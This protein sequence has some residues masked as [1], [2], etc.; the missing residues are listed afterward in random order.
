M[1]FGRRVF[2]FDNDGIKQISYAKYNRLL[3]GN[4]NE[5]LPEYANQRIRTAVVFVEIENRNPVNLVKIDCESI[6]VNQDGKFDQHERQQRMID[7]FGTISVP[8][9]DE[10]L[11]IVI[12]VSRLF[13]QKIDRNK[14]LWIPTNYEI[15]QIKENIFKK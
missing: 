13:A 9:I 8:T 7:A 10:P 15:Q 5:R 6:N 2:I 11:S 12:D 3:Q 1:G 14:H 4:E